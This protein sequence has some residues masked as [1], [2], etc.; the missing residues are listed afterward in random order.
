ME[1]TSQTREAAHTTVKVAAALVLVKG[2]TFL[3]TGSSGVLG[4]SLDSLLDVLASIIVLWAVIAS[5]RPADADHP[6]GHGKAE[7]LAA[8][9]QSLF[10]LFS[11]L[12]LAIHTAQRFLA[13]EAASVEF[14][15]VGIGVIAASIA[16]TVWQVKRLRKAASQ[17][18]SPALNADSQHYASDVFLN[19]G[20][21]AGLAL[22]ELFGGRAWPDLAVGLAIA[23]WILNTAREVFLQALDS[24]MDRGLLPQEAAAILKAV[25]GFSPQVSGFHDLR[26][27]RSGAEIFVEIHL[28]IDRAVTFV[29]A[30]DLSEEVGQALE[31]AVPR[32]RVTVHAD[33]L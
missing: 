24:L 2:T 10:I 12:G 20:V 19:I 17:T 27:R 3:L 16:V 1:T 31:E 4:S 5:G 15:W 28:D 21:I 18:G 22:T 7:G 11:G 9:F 8:L 13:P 33:P 23:L 30:H 6:W 29:E 26:T 25:S 32:C 14:P